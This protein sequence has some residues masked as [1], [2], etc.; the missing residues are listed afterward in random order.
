[1]FAIYH[2]GLDQFYDRGIRNEE[3]FNSA[4]RISQCRVPR[5]VTNMNFSQHP[6]P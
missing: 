1:L 3:E 5:G 6:E 2:N 4:F